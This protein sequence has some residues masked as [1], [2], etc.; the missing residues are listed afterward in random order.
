MPLRMLRL[1]LRRLWRHPVYAALN[2][3]GLA[4]GLVVFLLISLYVYHEHTYDTYHPEDDRI[5]RLAVDYGSLGLMP[6]APAQTAKRLAEAYPEIETVARLYPEDV[7]L[8]VGDRRLLEEQFFY[9]DPS[10]FDLFALPLLRGSAATALDAPDTVVLTEATARRFFG[11]VDVVGKTLQRAEAPPLRV[12]GVLK[13]LPSNTH[14]DIDALISYATL[15]RDELTDFHAKAFG[16]QGY[17]YYR[18]TDARAAVSLQAKLDTLTAKGTEAV[19]EVTGFAVTNTKFDLQAL[20]DLHL[21]ATSDGGD[22]APPV[23]PR[24]LWMFGGLGVFILGIAIINYVNLAT[25]QAGRRAL[26]VGVRKAMGA[27]RGNLVRLFLGEAF[28]LSLA[29]VAG[30]AVLIEALRPLFATLLG[31]SLSALSFQTPVVWGFYLASAGVVA[32]LAGSYP[33]WGLTRYRPAEVMRGTS[34]LA[35]GGRRFRQGLVVFQFAAS[36]VLIALTFVIREQVDYALQKPLGYAPENMVELPLAGALGD[37][38]EVFR[39]EAE[40]LPGIE[41][42]A[43]GLGSPLAHSV[44]MARD[45]SGGDPLRV[46]MVY[47]DARYPETVGFDLRVG[48]AYTSRPADS[49]AVLVN[50]TA[51]RMYG[52]YDQ[53]DQPLDARSGPVREG[54]RVVGVVGDFHMG[55]F[56][57]PIR[58]TVIERNPERYSAVVVRLQPERAQ[59][60]LRALEQLWYTVAPNQPFLY[61][62][63]D[64]FIQQQYRQERT[65]ARRLG[66]F[67][68]LAVLVAG[69]GLF[70]LAAFT[71]EQ[72][73]KE[74]SIRKVLGASIPQI[75]LRLN[76]EFVAL[77]GVAFA[78][79]LPLSLWIALRWLQDF[80]YRMELSPVL[81]AW[82][83]GLALLAALLPVSY[84]ALRA[85]TADPATTLRSE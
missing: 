13:A 19:Q 55:S 56:R 24:V 8:R 78:V 71:A 64:E 31:T 66:A 77:V 11:T 73:M 48:R 51:A 9:A 20:T 75:V 34:S 18:L 29:A 43:R 37:Q 82:A 81:F 61:R 68:L 84:H 6:R 33:A 26:E 15:R 80:A 44:T 40:R 57:E 72:R 62:F 2:G 22:M 76:R 28:V 54:Q 27:H 38:L 32:L 39:Q 25:A 4:I 74:M 67:A 12:T 49:T 69:L 45:P 47:G 83:G 79:A 60:A 30:A 35:V 42:A 23:D 52:L 10:V 63:T 41:A 50:E 7:A 21:S 46:H 3:V 5:V 70:G 65:L 36:I 59:E 16:Q 14:L 53:L 1:A 58:P 85:A 17:T